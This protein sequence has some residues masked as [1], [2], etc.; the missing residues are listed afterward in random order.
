MHLTTKRP[1]SLG[2]ISSSLEVEEVCEEL[3]LGEEVGEGSLST[4]PLDFNIMFLLVGQF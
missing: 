1:P 2:L 3:L 4:S